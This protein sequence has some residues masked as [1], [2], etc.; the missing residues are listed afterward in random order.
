MSLKC[1]CARSYSDAAEAM[2]EG[3]VVVIPATTSSDQCLVFVTHEANTQLEKLLRGDLGGAI[4]VSSTVL[5][6]I[7]YSVPFSHAIVVTFI[8]IKLNS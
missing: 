8:N 4:E 3:D 1:K 6:I 7:C 5:G 2:S